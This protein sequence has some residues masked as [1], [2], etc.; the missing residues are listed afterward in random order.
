MSRQIALM[1]LFTTLC[2]GAGIPPII[3][4]NVDI[5]NQEIYRFDMGAGRRAMQEGEEE[6]A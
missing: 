1:Y 6:E 2:A 4:P 5:E 3:V